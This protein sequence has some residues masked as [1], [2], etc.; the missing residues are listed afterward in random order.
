MHPSPFTRD[1]STA[2]KAPPWGAAWS[3][4]PG[5]S[6]SEKQAVPGVEGYV[7]T[8]KGTSGAAHLFGAEEKGESRMGMAL[9]P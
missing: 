2:H 8:A 1:C 9:Q 7:Q 6:S 4:L 3:V 5:Q